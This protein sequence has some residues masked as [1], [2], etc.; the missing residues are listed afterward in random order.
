MPSLARVARSL[1]NSRAPPVAVVLHPPAP[2]LVEVRAAD[3]L[4][5]GDLRATMCFELHAN[6]ELRIDEPVREASRCY[7]RKRMLQ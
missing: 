1:P 3:K 7:T 2:A 6:V 5:T 4:Y